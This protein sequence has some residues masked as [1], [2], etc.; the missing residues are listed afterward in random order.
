MRPEEIRAIIEANPGKKL[1]VR[2]N[3][4]SP[5]GVIGTFS[6]ISKSRAI[7]CAR[8]MTEV[9]YGTYAERRPGLKRSKLLS[10]YDQ[11]IVEFVAGG[12]P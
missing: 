2:E 8:F 9:K 1:Y 5:I 10:Y 11:Q 6:P 4:S 3:L 7:R 12:A